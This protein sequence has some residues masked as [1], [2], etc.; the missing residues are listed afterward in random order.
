MS[1]D[2]LSDIIERLVRIEETGKSTLAQATKTNGRVDS[3]EKR[4]LGLE[5]RESNLMGKITII[6]SIVGIAVAGAAALMWDGIKRM[7]YGS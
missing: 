1:P 4:I 3:T 7:I 2:L 6:T 5:N